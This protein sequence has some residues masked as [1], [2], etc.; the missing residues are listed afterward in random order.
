MDSNTTTYT[1][2]FSIDLERNNYHLKMK[3]RKLKR[4]LVVAIIWLILIVYLVTPLSKINLKVYGNV[5]YSKE[6]LMN[7]AYINSDELWW[8][9]NKEKAIK[10]L[11]SYEYIENV[12]ISKSPFSTKMTIN[13]IFPIGY[14]GDNYVFSN[15]SLKNKN[16]YPLNSKIVNIA[17]FSLINNDKI[18]ALAYK[19]SNVPFEVRN[20]FESIKIE[21]IKATS[22]Y[23]DFI[24]I[25]G[26]DEKIGYFTIKTDLVYLDT[27]FNTNKYAK[28][29]EEISKNKLKYSRENRA[30]I[31]YLYPDEE[32]FHLVDSF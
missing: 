18:S 6:E 17:D 13:E 21:T 4:I 5:Y 1:K 15:G 10:T 8:L 32:E 12:S 2:T 26:Y 23:Y 28:I 19:Y 29:I 30:L 24:L 22:Y 27:K 3:K 25:D 16:S 9:F 11:E 31:A 7:M 20:N 14:I